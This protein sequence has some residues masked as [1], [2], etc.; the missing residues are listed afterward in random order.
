MTANSKPAAPDF[1]T[2]EELAA[3]ADAA[4]WRT[5]SEEEHDETKIHFENWGDE[6]IG[7]YKGNRKVENE[8]GKFTQFLFEHNGIHYFVNGN[9]N[10]VQGMSKVPIGALTRLRYIADKDTGQQTPMKLYKVD[11]ARAAQ[12]RPVTSSDNT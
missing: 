7:T 9:W 11:V 12:R 2:P 6:F 4:Q 1:L 3:E 8:N 10:L 5:V